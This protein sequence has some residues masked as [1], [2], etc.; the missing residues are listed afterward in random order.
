MD[1]QEP[2]P[3]FAV[4]DHIWNSS[5]PYVV[6]VVERIGKVGPWDAYLVRQHDDKLGV[7]FMDEARG[8]A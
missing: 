4:G 3:A 1:K 2:Q 7:I 6:G 8:A 5:F